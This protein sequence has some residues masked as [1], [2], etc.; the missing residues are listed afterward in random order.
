[1]KT[2]T[3]T[4]GSRENLI[5]V[6]AQ[7]NGANEADELT[8]ELARRASRIAFGHT[9]STVTDRRNTYRLSGDKARRIGGRPA[10]S[11][12]EPT[13]KMEITLP[14]S[15]RDKLDGI[16]D[17]RSAWVRTQIEQAGEPAKEG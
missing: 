2:C 6:T 11:E 5:T 15:L 14:A 8:P 16:T 7:I 4:A 17:N 12:T 3:V 13:V 9:S 1:M 10:L